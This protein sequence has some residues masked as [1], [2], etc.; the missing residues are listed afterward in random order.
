MGLVLPCLA[1]LGLTSFFIFT[2]FFYEWCLTTN[3]DMTIVLKH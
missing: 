3:E 2:I 1:V